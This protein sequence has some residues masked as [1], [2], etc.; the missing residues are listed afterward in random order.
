MCLFCHTLLPRRLFSV[1]HL[2]HADALDLEPD[3]LG[4]PAGPALAPGPGPHLLRAQA[5]G[6]VPA[7]SGGVRQVHTGGNVRDYVGWASDDN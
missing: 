3:D 7:E 1:L 4:L 2:D 6:P 5:P